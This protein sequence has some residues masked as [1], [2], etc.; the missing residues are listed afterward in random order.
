MPEIDRKKY[1][2]NAKVKEK[3][4]L[5]CGITFWTYRPETKYCSPL[6]NTHAYD[7]RRKAKEDA[8]KKEAEAIK[9]NPEKVRKTVVKDSQPKLPFEDKEKKISFVRKAYMYKALKDE[10]NI[11]ISTENQNKIDGI[12]V[13]KTLVL[14]IK[15]V[16]V[17]IIRTGRQSHD[18]LLNYI[19]K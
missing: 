16:K 17:T 19:G 9:P 15:D 5:Q 3:K 18:I 6:C 14:N 8:I 10:L 7:E 1:P 4:C 2:Y 11:N 13:G 12:Q